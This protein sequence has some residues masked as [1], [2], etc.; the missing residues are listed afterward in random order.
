MLVGMG[1]GYEND[2][3]KYSLDDLETTEAYLSETVAEWRDG[4][5]TVTETMLDEMKHEWPLI[6][7]TLLLNRNNTWIPIIENFL[8]TE[9]VEFILV[10]LAHLHGPDGL[11]RHFQ[12]NGYTVRPAR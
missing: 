4:G 5:A 7:Q 10:G 8:T 12:N 9:P 3:V 6:Y 1:D 2:Y 11:L